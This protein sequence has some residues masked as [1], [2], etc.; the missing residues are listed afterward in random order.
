MHGGRKNPRLPLVLIEIPVVLVQD[1]HVLMEHLPPERVLSRA[2]AMRAMG[3]A[4]SRFDATT[5]DDEMDFLESLHDKLLGQAQELSEQR[6]EYYLLREDQEASEQW[7]EDGEILLLG[8]FDCF[9]SILRLVSGPSLDATC[10]FDFQGTQPQ[11]TK[12]ISHG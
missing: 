2:A 1:L 7:D 3:A 4:I 6:N 9:L 12:S 10:A 8:I 11:T 5:A